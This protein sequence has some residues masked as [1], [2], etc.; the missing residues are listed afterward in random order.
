[1]PPDATVPK[2]VREARVPSRGSEGELSRTLQLLASI[3]ES[4][5]DAIISENLDGTITSWNRGAE[6]VFGY[7]AEEAVGRPI[8]VLYTAG[9]NEEMPEILQRIRAGER[10]DHYETVRRHKDGHLVS[11]LL[12]VSPIRDEAGKIIGASKIARD[13]TQLKQLIEQEQLSRAESRFR[14]LLEAAPDAI[15]EVDAEGHIVLLNDTAEKMF[16]Y[17][18]NELLG[19]N[20]DNLVPTALR[21]GHSRRRSSYTDHPQTR[22]MGT[23]LELNAERKDGTLFPVEISL[24]PNRTDEGLRVIAIVRDISERKQAEDKLRAVREHYTAELAAKNAQL[25]ARNREVEKANRLKSEFLAS[26]SHELRTPLH[27]VIGFS[28]LLTEES[29]GQLNPKQKRFLGHILQDSRHLLELI[30]EVLDLSK[31][32]AGKLELQLEEFDFSGCATEVFAAIRYRAEAKNIQL[33]NRSHIALLNA[34]S[35][36]VKE[37]LY[38]LLSNAIKFTPN[39]G[40]VWLESVLQDGF[41]KVTVG[42]TGIGVAPEEQA[43]I[44]EKFYQVGDTTSGI[45]EGT[46]LGLAITKRLVEMHGGGI[47][48]ESQKGQ[49]SRFSFTLPLAKT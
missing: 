13:V 7:T 4:S 18:R 42:D 46:G 28:E 44:F 49:G 39:G 30:N 6:R 35:L 8:S 9:K 45:R 29:E 40:S 5:D 36:R 25:E 21:S 17:A 19:L 48:L 37:I 27:T 15:L 26:M 11:V 12:T 16:G 10:V 14:K 1:M 24:S 32:E 2:P 20:V 34:D 38:N 31:I 3:V 33:E 47:W 43:A 22:P 23:G 41:L